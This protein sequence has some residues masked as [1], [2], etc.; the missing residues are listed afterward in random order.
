MSENRVGDEDLARA[1]ELGRQ[2]M[3]TEFRAASVRYDAARDTVELSM[4]DGWGLVFERRAVSQFAEVPPEE[5]ARLEVSPVGTGLLLD[6]RDIHVN[7]HGLV[8]SF[9]SP[10]LMA[11][12]LGRKGGASSSDAK[13]RSSRENGRKG[14]RPKK[15]KAA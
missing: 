15:V 6:A 5:M 8:T 2:R 1:V 10:H 3:A 9:I 4:V 12:T 13:K 14:G 7:V 11:S